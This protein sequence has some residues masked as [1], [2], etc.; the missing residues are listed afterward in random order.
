MVPV[1]PLCQGFENVMRVKIC[2]PLAREQSD[3]AELYARL[4]ARWA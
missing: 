4:A 2:V 3:V 1:V